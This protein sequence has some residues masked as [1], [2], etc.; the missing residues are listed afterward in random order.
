MK[1]Q[2]SRE[3][4]KGFVRQYSRAIR[5]FPENMD[6]NVRSVSFLSSYYQDRGYVFFT[7]T[8][9]GYR[10]L[11]NE[12]R[13]KR[14]AMLTIACGVAKNKFPH[15]KKVIG[16]AI[17]APKFTDRNS[18]DFLMIDTENWTDEE[19]AFYNQQNKACKFFETPQLR[20]HDTRI[21][22]FPEAE[23]PLRERK[24]RR[25]DRCPCGSGL[26]YKRCHGRR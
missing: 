19:A 10:G 23:P 18:E 11:R 14:R 12:Y 22:E 16:I 3:C 21:R 25:N 2:K 4:A 13:P 26:K 1:W 9:H 17:D 15:L 8:G 24:F 7:T 20:R 5:E 6:G